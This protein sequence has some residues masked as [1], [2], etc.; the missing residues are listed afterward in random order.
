MV[1]KFRSKKYE[2]LHE[3][4][5]R[6]RHLKIEEKELLE[7]ARKM[8]SRMKSKK[9]IRDFAARMKDTAVRFDLMGTPEVSF[10]VIT[11]NG[12]L[13]FSDEHMPADFAFGI[14]KGLFLKLVGE[15]PNIGNLAFILNNISFR[16]GRVREC[17]RIKPMLID[18]VFGG[19]QPKDKP[20][21]GA[22]LP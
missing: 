14:S 4:K 7:S 13:R 3:R 10:F 6:G 21:G 1:K 2:I 19:A 11:D 22:N 5:V 9:R 18:A 8:F 20:A 15:E 17:L 16:K 12:K